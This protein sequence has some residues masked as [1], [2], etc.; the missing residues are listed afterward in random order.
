MTRTEKYIFQCIFPILLIIVS[1]SALSQN[2]VKRTKSYVKGFK[3]MK[4]GII[5]LKKG[6]GLLTLKTPDVPGSQVMD[7]RLL[8]LKRIN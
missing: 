7:F 3:P 1:I 6:Q 2:R 4:M 8:I 5:H